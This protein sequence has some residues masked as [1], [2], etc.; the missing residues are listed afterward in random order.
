MRKDFSMILIDL[1]KAF[2]SLSHNLLFNKQQDL[3]TSESST[4]WFESYLAE[5]HQTTR[6][7]CT[8]SSSLSSVMYFPKDRFSAPYC[9]PFT[10]MTCRISS[11]IAKLNL[12]WT[13]LS[14]FF[15]LNCDTD[16][17][18][19]SVSQAA[20][21]FHQLLMN[22]DKTKFQ[23]RRDPRMQLRTQ[24]MQLRKKPERNSGLQL[25]T[26]FVLFGTKQ[27]LGKLVNPTVSILSKTLTPDKI[28]KDLGIYLDRSV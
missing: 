8:L 9:S 16:L 12:T 6:I 7:V 22:P 1:S 4:K 14:C 18:L 27:E 21:D 5:R 11:E 24:F 25:Q 28:C 3:G 2:D 13:T 23:V 17:A 20:Q 19:A 15:P 26:K 10:S